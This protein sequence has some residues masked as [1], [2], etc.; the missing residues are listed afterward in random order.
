MQS[1]ERHYFWI[2]HLIQTGEINKYSMIFKNRQVQLCDLN[3]VFHRITSFLAWVAV[4][5]NKPWVNRGL[6]WVQKPNL[7]QSFMLETSAAYVQCAVHQKGQSPFAFYPDANPIALGCFRG[8]SVVGCGCLD[9]NDCTTQSI[10]VL[11]L[12]GAVQN[13]QLH[14]HMQ[15]SQMHIMFLL[16][17]MYQ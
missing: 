4:L 12:V 11:P 14:E 5:V 6:R 8:A 10:Q 1:G 7:F 15:T 9:L 3:L 2:L 16:G 13:I 17:Y